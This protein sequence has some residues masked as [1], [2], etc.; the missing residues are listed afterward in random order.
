MHTADRCYKEFEIAKVALR[1]PLEVYKSSS[2]SEEESKKHG[3]ICRVVFDRLGLRSI[4]VHQF[5]FLKVAVKQ[6]SGLETGYIAF[7]GAYLKV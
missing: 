3:G 2:T 7:A 6:E 1:N 4:N 5:H